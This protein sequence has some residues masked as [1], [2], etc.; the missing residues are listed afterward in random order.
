MEPINN[1]KHIF[2]VNAKAGRQGFATKLRKDLA[3]MPGLDY[4]VFNTRKAGDETD[5]VKMIQDFF[6]GEKLRF[7]CC[8]GSGTMRNMMNGFEK[9]EDAEIAFF[10]CGLTNDFIKTFGDKAK[11]FF[12]IKNLINGKV[13]HV[14][15]LKSNN[16]VMLNTFSTGMD[17][18][19]IDKMEDLRYLKLFNDNLPYNLGLVNAIFSNRS[20][21]FIVE[22]EDFSY[23]GAVTEIFFGNGS[24]LGGNLHF[25]DEI[26]HSDGLGHL[27]ILNPRPN[28]TL[29]RLM[30]ALLHKDM[31]Y[32]NKSSKFTNSSF[33][34]IRRDDNSEIIV[35]QDGE[36]IRGISEW[37][38]SVVPK[39]LNL[40]VPQE[41]EDA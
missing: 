41:V 40:I 3:Q 11:Y 8:G 17:S 22:G 15:Y 37:T 35:N 14:D 23:H 20:K 19:T 6:E 24:V 38:V 27:R 26:S 36:L 13:I 12:D 7:Y 18:T 10:P 32:I 33:I 31:D 1:M 4:Y 5:L 29:F 9:L 25:S 2:L 16:G 21:K 34:K 30:V 28:I 39:G